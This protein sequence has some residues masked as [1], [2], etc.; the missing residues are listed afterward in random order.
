LL[1]CFCFC[2]CF[3]S[4]KKKKKLCFSGSVSAVSALS[5]CPAKSIDR[6]SI[7]SIEKAFALYKFDRSRSN[8][9][10]RTLL[11]S[12]EFSKQQKTGKKIKK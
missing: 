10:D 4:K 3:C 12:C 7:R 11:R 9:I 5:E 8:L 1:F 6:V 2:F